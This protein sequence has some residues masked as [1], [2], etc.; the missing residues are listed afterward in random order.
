M[1]ADALHREAVHFATCDSRQARLMR[2]TS[3]RPARI[4][5]EEVDALAS[6][7]RDFH[8]HGRPLLLGRGPS[9]NA[10]Q[11]FA[12][13]H[14]E[15]EEIAERFARDAVEWL[16]A[17]ARAHGD[18][19]L[20]VFAEGRFLGHLRAAAAATRARVV[21]VHGNLAPLQASELASHRLIEDLAHARLTV[22]ARASGAEGEEDHR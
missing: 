21:F 20:A 17:R 8:E 2:A 3:P 19:P 4:H 22:A 11:H 13:E 16:D 12:D 1:S 18:A 6:R 15:V 5:V 9:A 10:A 7:W 14:R